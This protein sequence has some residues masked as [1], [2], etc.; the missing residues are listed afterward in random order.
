MGSFRH[1]SQTDV[2]DYR[3]G[4]ECGT[5]NYVGPHAVCSTDNGHVSYTYDANGNLTSDSR[6]GNLGGRTITYSTF[7]K[8]ASIQR[9]RHH[10]RFAYGPSRNRYLRADFTG[11][12]SKVTRYLGGVEKI[13]HS[14]GRL[15]IKRY[16][17]NALITIEATNDASLTEKVKQPVDQSAVQY[18]LKDHLGSM[19]VITDHFGNVTEA[20]SFDAW[21]ARRNALRWTAVDIAQRLSFN[22]AKTT[23]RGFTGHEMLDEVGLVHMNGRIYD[24]RIGRFVQADPF[25]QFKDMPQSYNR[26]SYVLNNPLTFDDPSGFLIGIA[27]DHLI[28]KHLPSELHPLLQI[29]MVASCGPAAPACSVGMAAY[30]AA[31]SAYAQTGS[32][33]AA[34]QSAVFAGV[35]AGAFHSIGQHFDNVTLDSSLGD[36]AGKI[37]AHGIT[38]GVMSV[39]QG[40]KFGHGFA[41]AG[42]SA[43]AAVLGVYGPGGE[44]ITDQGLVASIIVGGTASVITGGKFAN[45]A[46]TSAFSYMLNHVSAKEED[47]QKANNSVAT[48]DAGTLD[49]IIGSGNSLGWLDDLLKAGASR[50]NFLLSVATIPGSTPR[51]HRGRIQAQGGGLEASVPWSQMDPPTASEGLSMVESLKAQ[52]T[53]KQLKVRA[54]GFQQAERFIKNA[55]KAGGVSAPVSRTFLTQ[56]T[57]DI[58]VD[59]EVITGQ[60]FVP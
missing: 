19:D 38:G 41:S 11:S 53:S 42:V 60:A 13:S 55:G 36:I 56:G 25:V 43:G 5:S 27:L 17:G 4:D 18:L 2:G 32:L 30:G 49:G 8:P 16:V 40:G 33:E 15:E 50:L 31:H 57:K 7:D 58:R 24:A 12:S 35:S 46:L 3:Y 6:H 39:M 59:I 28:F 45:G 21:G 23:T 1:F 48:A 37:A 10:T 47:E 52:L 9:G 44:G 29:A 34:F 51:M 26:Y 20:M 54:K 22:T 14:D